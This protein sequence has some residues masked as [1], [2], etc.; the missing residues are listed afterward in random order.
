MANNLRGKAKFFCRVE[1]NAPAVNVSRNKAGYNFP[2][3]VESLAVR[4]PFPL[5]R[6]SERATHLTTV[7][8]RGANAGTEGTERERRHVDAHIAIFHSAYDPAN[9][10]SQRL[11]R[12][13]CKLPD[14]RLLAT[15]YPLCAPAHR[16]KRRGGGEEE[17][18]TLEERENQREKRRERERSGR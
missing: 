18:Q 4:N 8:Q 16:E 10:R 5:Y 6:V 7:L 13:L 12:D 1:K 11:Q 9:S 17:D 15:P 3:A 2:P 14:V